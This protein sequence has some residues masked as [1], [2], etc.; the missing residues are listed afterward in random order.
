MLRYFYLKCRIWLLC[1]C[2]MEHLP[3]VRCAINNLLDAYPR[4]R[5]AI[6]NLLDAYPRVRCAINKVFYPIPR[7]RCAINNL[8]YPIPHPPKAVNNFIYGTPFPPK[9]VNRFI[10]LFI[11]PPKAKK[12]IRR[13]GDEVGGE[14]MHIISLV[15]S[16]LVSFKIQHHSFTTFPAF[17][18]SPFLF[19]ML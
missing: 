11:F 5:C 15:F 14:E 6:N 4:V 19:T 3:R 10:F 17:T 12:A 9:V 18:R 13:T 8:F 1:L 7:V 2:F 16:F